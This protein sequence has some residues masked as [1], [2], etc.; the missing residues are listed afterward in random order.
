MS[1]PFSVIS[2][3]DEHMT[4]SLLRAS[5]IDLS[6]C[7]KFDSDLDLFSKVV[8]NRFAVSMP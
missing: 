4:L 6:L 2:L 3:L 7:F 5:N 1:T 8:L